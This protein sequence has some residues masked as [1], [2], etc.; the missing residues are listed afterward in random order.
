MS[1]SEVKSNIKARV[2]KAIAQAELDVSAL[3]KETLESL[4]DLVAEAAMLESD[5]ELDKSMASR[6][7]ETAVSND[8][9]NDGKEDILWEG[10]PFLSISLQYTITDERIR[11]T[12]GFLGKARENVELVRI[13]DVDFSQTFSERILNLGDINV[14]SHDSSNPIIVLKN[15]KDPEQVYEILRRAVLN[16]RKKHNFTY[17]EE[18]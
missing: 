2:W 4:V 14:R 7:L 3:S 15:I 18:M 13:Q 10:R 6:G 8:V 16:A 12:E 11:I 17:R 5:A 9:L 1:V